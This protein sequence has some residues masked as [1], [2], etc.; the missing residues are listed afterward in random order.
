MVRPFGTSEPETA[1]R[2]YLYLIGC[3]EDRRSVTYGELARQ[4]K[5]GDLLAKPLDL[6][7]KYCRA[8]KLPVLAALVVEQATRLPAPGFNVVSRQELSAEQERVW[9]YDWFA[10]YPPAVEELT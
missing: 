6:I 10:I 2:A 3:A 9:D 1:L 8:N 4:V 7:T 5:R